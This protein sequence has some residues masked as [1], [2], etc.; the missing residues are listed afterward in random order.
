MLRH[1]SDAG[2][3]GGSSGQVRCIELFDD[4]TL[5]PLRKESPIPIPLTANAVLLVE[6]EG[7]ERHVEHAL[8]EAGARL[9]VV[10]PLEILVAKHAADRERIW[11]VRRAMSYTLKRSARFKRSD[12]V[13]VPRSRLGELLTQCRRIAELGLRMPS[14]G[15]AGDGNLHVNF[16][17]DDPRT[18]AVEEARARSSSRRWCW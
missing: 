15:H 7:G 18:A 1:L 13:V 4:L 5:E 3:R 11:S 16:L 12:D 2:D 17:W 10:Q 9:E 8:E 14:Y 6:F